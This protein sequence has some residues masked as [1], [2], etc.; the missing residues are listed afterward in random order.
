MFIRHVPIP[1]HLPAIIVRYFVPD[2]LKAGGA[3]EEYTGLIRGVDSVE[4]SIVFL[5][6]NGRSKGKRIEIDAICEIHGELVDCQ[7][8]VIG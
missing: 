1:P 3:Y 8:D 5:A 4:G 2:A 6:D 7:D